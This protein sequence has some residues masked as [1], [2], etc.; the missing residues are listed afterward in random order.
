LKRI[1]TGGRPLPIPVF[2]PYSGG[3]VT[4]KAQ[5]GRREQRRGGHSRNSHAG[6]LYVIGTTGATGTT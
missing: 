3:S 2:F 6:I 4:T 5:R 1:A